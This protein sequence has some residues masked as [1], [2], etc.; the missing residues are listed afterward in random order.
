MSRAASFLHSAALFAVPSVF[1]PAAKTAPS[2]PINPVIAAQRASTDCLDGLR[3]IAAFAVMIFHYSC[4]VFPTIRH[5]F[6]YNNTYH[7][8]QLPFVKIWY[9]G[10][11]MVYLFFV[12]SGY[13]LSARIVR[14]VSRKEQDRILPALS[15]L[16]FRRTARLFIPS[17]IASF[18]AFLC[19]RFGWMGQPPN[20]VPS[21]TADVRYYIRNVLD[22]FTFYSW[23]TLTRMWHLSPLWTIP[24][25][26]RCS[27]VLFLVLLALARCRRNMRLIIQSVLLADTFIHDRWDVGCFIL[28]LIA[29]EIHV[30]TQEYPELPSKEGSTLLHS[31]DNIDDND[32][33]ADSISISPYGAPSKGSQ[34]LRTA[35]LWTMFILGMYLGSVPTEFA[36]DTPGY[37]TLCRLSWHTEPWRY[38]MLPAG[39]LIILPI[40]FIPALQKP[41]VSGP[42]RYLGKVS[43]AMYLMHEMIN[44]CIG[45]NFRQF[46]WAIFGKEGLGFYLGFALG[47]LLFITFSLWVAD[48]FMRA[49][50][51][52]ATSFARFAEEMCLD[53]SEQKHPR[54][55][56]VTR[57]PGVTP[58]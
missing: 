6:G 16:T 36:C 7:L 38:I 1:S 43:Y 33:P 18:M 11:F 29:A 54:Q 8:I 44:V 19:H 41:L 58:P 48:M 47:L 4:M 39:F 56:A 5:S 25:E 12:I 26:F 35:G 30:H 34:K 22:L 31:F 21:F 32:H 27:M 45:K 40:L 13:V 14:M 46:G 50:D 51:I 55:A 10:G 42:A 20:H 52:P 53:K 23:S 2:R 49:I 17:L 9:S 28:G 57:L 37:Q 3:G 15:S 24:V